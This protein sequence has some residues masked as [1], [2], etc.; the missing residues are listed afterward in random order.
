MI[1]LMLGIVL[2][3][4]YSKTSD[5]RDL[6]WLPKWGKDYLLYFL[7]FVLTYILQILFFKN[8]AF[9]RNKW[10]W[11][12]V[13]SAPAFFCLRVN[14]NFS[15]LADYFGWQ[16]PGNHFWIYTSTLLIGSFLLVLPAFLLWWLKDQGDKSKYGFGKIENFRV[17]FIMLMLMLPL[18][19]LAGFLPEFLKQYPMVFRAMGESPVHK[20]FYVLLY[21][22]V[23]A[24]NFLGIEFFFRGFLILA[25]VR[26]AGMNAILPAAAFYCCIHLNK[27]L[28]EAISSFFGGWLLGIISYNTKSIWGGVFIHVGIAMFMELVAFLQHQ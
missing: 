3:C 12:F 16:E 14:Y 6:I 19:V 25:F 1:V 7:P 27:P 24:L 21:E 4:N 28:P 8:I 17:Y 9:I 20:Y 11:I 5:T 26:I 13:V 15:Q 22:L 18:V 2:Y 10:F 23:Y